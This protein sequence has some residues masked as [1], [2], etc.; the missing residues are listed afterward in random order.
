VDRHTSRTRPASVWAI[1]L[2]VVLG[3]TLATAGALATAAVFGAR[4]VPLA[5]LAYAPVRGAARPSNLASLTAAI[6]EPTPTPLPVDDRFDAARALGHVRSIVAFGPRPAG[7]EAESRAVDY[8]RAQFEVLGYDTTVEDVPLPDG[9]TTHNVVAHKPGGGA[10]LVVVGGH[11]D[12]KAPAPGANDD[13]SG[14]GVALELARVMR[15]RGS[16]PSLEFVAFGGEEAAGS[17]DQ[18]HYGSRAH[19]FSLRTAHPDERIAMVAVDMVGVGSM[20]NVRSMGRGPQGLVRALS[21]YAGSHKVTLRYLKDTARYGSADHEPFELA[22]MPAAWLE[23]RDDPNY[24]TKRDTAD[25]IKT[26]RLLVTGQLLLGFLSGVT[27]DDVAA[28]YAK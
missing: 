26:A 17:P 5:P 8:V 18:H 20:F 23:W 21:A 19:A 6:A 1:P 14:V 16:A 28:W 10:G 4:F 15:N 7:S 9:K 13:A 27:S 22:G 25:R 3:V 2:G 11:I 24:H 12:S